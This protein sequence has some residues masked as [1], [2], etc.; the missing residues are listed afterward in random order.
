[1]IQLSAYGS[2]FSLYIY[3]LLLLGRGAGAVRLPP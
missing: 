1:M 3:G 2:F